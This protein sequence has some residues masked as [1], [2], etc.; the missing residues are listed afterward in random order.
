MKKKFLLLFI[1]ILT[2]LACAVGFAGC[3]D[4]EE[5]PSANGN[6]LTTVFEERDDEFFLVT[7]FVTGGAGW[8]GG[9][10]EGYTIEDLASDK[11]SF[12]NYSSFYFKWKSSKYTVTKIEFDVTAQTA[13]KTTFCLYNPNEKNSVKLD[14]EI[15]AGETKHVSFECNFQKNTDLFR[16]YNQVSDDIKGTV[17]WKL[18]NLYVTADKK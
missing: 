2:C 7:H 1:T 16:I 11:L 14:V 15:A 10:V 3:N 6:M 5:K 12:N 13:M 8:T 17:S 9:E 4:E 18:S